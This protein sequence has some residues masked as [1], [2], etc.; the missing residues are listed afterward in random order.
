MPLD[1]NKMHIR[2]PIFAILD[3]YLSEERKNVDW[4][5]V[6]P[7]KNYAIKIAICINLFFL[8]EFVHNHEVE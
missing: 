5:F 2:T 6:W 7:K 3:T 1:I 4:I 8:A